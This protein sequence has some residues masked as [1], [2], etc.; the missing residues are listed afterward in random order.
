MKRTLISTTL[1]LAFLTPPA[2][3]MVLDFSSTDW[4]TIG[5]PGHAETVFE[6][7]SDGTLLIRADSSVG[8]YH[9]P[10]TMAA[11]LLT[12]RW[13]VDAL[14]APSDP[15]EVGADDRP[16]AVHLW[17]PAPEEQRSLFGGMAEMFG[18]P[19]VGNALT[20]M[21][22]ASSDR[23]EVMPNPHLDDNRGVLITLRTGMDA[24]S[25]WLSESIDYRADF[26]AAFGRE[27]PAPTHIAISGDSDDLGGERLAR[28]R[29]LGFQE[30]P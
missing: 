29:D 23:P 5:V 8:F 19:R 15:S 22:G 16:I 10:L 13:R 2:H 9:Q 28:I 17:F 3:G 4:E 20:Y 7:M 27:A 1:L 6:T 14:G 30:G 12:W 26:K 21:W 24:T 25:T 11:G 18:F